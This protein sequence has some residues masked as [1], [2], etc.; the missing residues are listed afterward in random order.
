MGV[1]PT[2]IGQTPS[3]LHVV[4]LRAHVHF[5]TPQ[6]HAP[7]KSVEASGAGEVQ[8]KWGTEGGV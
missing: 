7:T 8:R 3:C 1:L 5:F 6:K 2:C 4:T